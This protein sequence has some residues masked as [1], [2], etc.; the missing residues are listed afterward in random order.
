MKL[1]TSLT[2]SAAFVQAQDFPGFGGSLADLLAQLNIENQLDLG[3]GA[4]AGNDANV[5]ST[6][7]E[8][9]PITGERYLIANTEPNPS[10]P[11]TNNCS[12][13][14]ENTAAEDCNP[15]IFDP[16]VCNG[17][18]VSCTATDENGI[19]LGIHDN[20]T[21]GDESDDW[22]IYECDCTTHVEVEHRTDSE[23]DTWAGP[24]CQCTRCTPHD[25]TPSSDPD[26]GEDSACTANENPCTAVA[27]DA[28]IN[29]FIDDSTTTVDT[30]CTE[31]PSTNDYTCTCQAN[32][33]GQHCEWTDPCDN[34]FCTGA[35]GEQTVGP[36][37]ALNT[38]DDECTCDCATHPDN[39]EASTPNNI[40]GGLQCNESICD[41]A[42]VACVNGSLTN[43][44]ETDPTTAACV[45]TCGVNWTGADC[46][47]D[48]CGSHTC[49]NGGTVDRSVEGQCGCTCPAGFTGASCETP[50]NAPVGTGCWKCDAMTYVQCATEGSF[51]T[52]SDDNTNGDNGVC[53]VEYREQ[54]QKLTQLCT[55]CKDAK[56]SFK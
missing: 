33:Y 18:P 32:Y 36:D 13:T 17:S 19:P 25:G 39:V 29:D 56:E 7:G 15:C 1:F 38:A 6:E 4:A 34:D 23:D 12:G 10:T 55:G 54:N 21:E 47:S 40:W 51:Q 49:Q 9:D 52:C 14:V 53:F 43:D 11:F 22:W 42:P 50:T 24:D 35:E 8:F 48:F 20:G 5:N 28:N 16:N 31:T 3:I 37:N 2:A 41:R 30:I 44:L 45:C 27:N 26:S 46:S